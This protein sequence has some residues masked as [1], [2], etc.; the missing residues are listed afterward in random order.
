M[1][2]ESPSSSPHTAG[3]PAFTVVEMLVSMVVIV[4]IV[5]LVSQLTSAATNTV[6]NSRK[7][8][9]ADSQARLILN[10]M[11]FDFSNMIQRPDLDYSSFKQPAGSLS[12]TY[13][14]GAIPVN[15]QTGVSGAPANDS[16]AFYA[17][18]VGYFSSGTTPPASSTRASLALVAYNMADDQYFY[19]GQR[20][21]LQRMGKGLGWESDPA[22][23]FQNIAYLPMTLGIQ[24]PSLFASDPNWKTVGDQV[25]R[26]EYTHL[27]K[28][29]FTDPKN[30]HP[31]Q[32]SNTPYWDATTNKMMTANPH[33]NINGFQDVAAI[34]VAIAVLDS[35][36]ESLVSNTNTALVAAFPDAVEGSD[37]RS[38][39]LAKVNSP[40]LRPLR[41]FPRQQLP[42]SVFINDTFTWPPSFDQ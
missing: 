10:R 5:V 18:G 39:W 23:S 41:E 3:K 29:N 36:S 7:H 13:S 31:A 35:T 25:F 38:A 40:A 15:L 22:G 30:P 6:S 11:A 33:T 34:V 8:I 20:A 21:V 26:F 12:A 37:I 1:N 27:L 4:L 28:P 24:W 2:P 19:S 14:S 9:D 32:L 42:P 16:L 17:K